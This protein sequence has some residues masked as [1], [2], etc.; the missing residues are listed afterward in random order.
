MS[1]DIRQR[2]RGAR[3]LE[4]LERQSVELTADVL[5]VGSFVKKARQSLVLADPY[6]LPRPR[7]NTHSPAR[8]C[9]IG[10]DMYSG[11][12]IPG[13]LPKYDLNK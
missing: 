6:L 1:P 8:V 5:L 2:E 3:M 13:Y 12:Y 11:V 7:E 9:S 10:Y 4:Y